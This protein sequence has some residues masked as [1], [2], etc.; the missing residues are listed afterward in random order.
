MN[1]SLEAADRREYVMVSNAELKERA[2]VAFTAQRAPMIWGFAVVFAIGLIE[3]APTTWVNWQQN[4]AMLNNVHPANLP[5]SELALAAAFLAIMLT[6]V[7]F[8][9]TAS[10]SGM[11]LDALDGQRVSPDDL[12]SRTS[13]IGRWATLYIIMTVKIFL[14]TLLFIIPGI[15]AAFNYSQAVYLMLRDPDLKPN[16]AIKESA[17]LVK[18]YRAD[19]FVLG[20][21]FILWILLVIVTF[22]LALLYVGPYMELT[23]AAFHN[24]L[25]DIKHPPGQAIATMTSDDGAVFE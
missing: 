13:E 4:M 9:I 25:Y 16:D 2:K 14:W 15:I 6:A 3:Q 20:L 5:S 22:G 21:S 11:A 23:F 8:F 7:F 12:L 19:L 18:G 1:S 24:E 10:Y 17:K